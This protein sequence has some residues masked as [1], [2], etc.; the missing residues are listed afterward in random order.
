MILV[1][2][3]WRKISE[4]E[5]LAL[6]F[7]LAGTFG[8]LFDRIFRGFV[9]DFIDFGFWPAFNIADISNVIGALLL[10]YLFI[11]QTLNKTPIR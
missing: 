1:I 7:I 5:Q 8:N 9:I 11:F 2:Y 4:Q 6:S 10:V 3:Y